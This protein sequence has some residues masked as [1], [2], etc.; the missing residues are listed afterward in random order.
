MKLVLGQSSVGMECDQLIALRDAKG[1]RICCDS[2]T[3]WI[4]QEKRRADI[5]LESGQSLVIDTRGLTLVMALRP[6]TL[7]L[8]D[9]VSRLSGLWQRLV[10]LLQSGLLN[11]SRAQKEGSAA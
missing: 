4:T 7:R 2:G 8:R 10:G 5:L 3:L 1:V 9:G 6:S 11:P